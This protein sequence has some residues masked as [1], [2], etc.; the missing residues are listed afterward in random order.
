MTLE[1]KD[2][3][4]RIEEG[5]SAPHLTLASGETHENVSLH[6]LFPLS[7]PKE[8]ISVKGSDGK[9]IGVIESM[10]GLDGESKLVVDA[11]LQRRYFTPQILKINTLVNERGLWR[12]VVETH[13]G[14]AEFFV[15]DWRD[16]SFE[17]TPGRWHILSVEGQRFT[18]EKLEDLDER[19]QK[20]LDQIL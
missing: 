11:E 14:E 2:L 18:I 8:F 17:L 12:W 4:F 13:R 15:R 20:L 3:R 16:S 7:L 6:R 9:E 1:A 5:A 19:S 10:E